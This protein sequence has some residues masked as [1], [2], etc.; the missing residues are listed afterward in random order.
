[1]DTPFLSTI[2][3]GIAAMGWRVVR[4]EFPYMAGRRESPPSKRPPDRMP[5]LQACWAEVI[6]CVRQEFAPRRLVLAGKSMGGR[7]ASLIADQQQANGL[8][9]LGFPLHPAGKPDKAAERGAHLESLVTPTL[10]CQGTRDALGGQDAFA[11]VSLAPTVSLCWLLDGD[12][13]FKPRKSSG[14]SEQHAFSEALEAMRSF[15]KHA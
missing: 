2:A 13:S 5:V 4:F 8:I 15:L 7:V 1:M 3:E 14:R 9:V 12:H 10:I 6:A 11:A